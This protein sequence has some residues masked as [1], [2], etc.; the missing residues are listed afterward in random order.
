MKQHSSTLICKSNTLNRTEFCGTIEPTPTLE[1]GS[2]PSVLQRRDVIYNIW[3][4]RHA[5]EG[6]IEAVES[7]RNNQAFDLVELV[8]KPLDTDTL[9]STTLFKRIK[10][11]FEIK[12][13]V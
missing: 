11:N 2:R 8:D 10:K 12:D 5:L 4:I 13:S 6:P 3:D 7:L 9:L 1:N